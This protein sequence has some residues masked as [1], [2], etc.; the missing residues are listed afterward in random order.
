MSKRLPKAALSTLDDIYREQAQAPAATTPT[1]APAPSALPV[2]VAAAPATPERDLRRVRCE[3]IVERHATYAALGGGIPLP[4]LDS[5]G[6]SLII[7]N[8]VQALARQHG[9]TVRQEQLKPIVAALI[10]GLFSASAGGLATAL[11]ERIIPGA[12]IIGSAASS[13][14]AAACTR[15]IGDQFIAHFESGGTAIDADIAQWRVQI[16]AKLAAL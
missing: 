1:A 2:V 11:A 9:V 3:L 10:G 5:I 15:Y 13:A 8:M 14:A 16:K 7:H 4:L 6:V 12:W